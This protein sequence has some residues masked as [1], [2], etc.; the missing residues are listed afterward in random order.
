VFLHLSKT[1]DAV[2]WED[3]NIIVMKNVT[4]SP[5]YKSDNCI[6]HENAPLGSKRNSNSSKDLEAVAYIKQLV[7]KYWSDW[8]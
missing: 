5:P 7:E 3:Q 4:I 8:K 1:I 6:P 2:T